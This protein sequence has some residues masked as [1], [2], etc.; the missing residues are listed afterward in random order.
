MIE[1]DLFGPRCEPDKRV[2]MVA[3]VGGGICYFL[4]PAGIVDWSPS[5]YRSDWCFIRMSRR[6]RLH[7][8]P[9]LPGLLVWASCEHI[10]RLYSEFHQCPILLPTIS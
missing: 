4:D 8:N 9:N 2:L 5:Y 6:E 3:R 1:P 10:G 7:R